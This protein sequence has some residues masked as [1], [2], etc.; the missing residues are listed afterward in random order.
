M[1]T[2]STQ[3][4]RRTITI[5]EDTYRQLVKARTLMMAAGMFDKTR[6]TWDDVLTKMAQISIAL[7]ADQITKNPM[8]LY[9]TD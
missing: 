1:S 9:K 5:D 3:K 6:V 7:A 4:K 2:A 8:L